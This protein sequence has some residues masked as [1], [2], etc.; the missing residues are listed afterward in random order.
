[1]D[2]HLYKLSATSLKRMRKEDPKLV[3]T[4]DRL[5]INILSRRLEY[6]DKQVKLLF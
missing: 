2:N 5:I 1:M 3:S 6:L 4:L